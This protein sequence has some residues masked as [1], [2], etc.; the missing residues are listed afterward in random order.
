MIVRH[1]EHYSKIMRFAKN[2][3]AICILFGSNIFGSTIHINQNLFNISVDDIGND[4]TVMEYSFGEFK[5]TDVVI[6]GDI[7]SI[8]NVGKEVNIHDMGS[9]TL[10]KI[11]RSI[12]I[13]DDK[14]M[15]VNI[16][17]SEFIEYSFKIA[18]GKGVI[19]RPDTPSDIPFTFSDIYKQNEYYPGNLSELGDPYIL[20]DFRGQTVTVYPFQYNPVTHSL[21]VY[22]H[23]KIEIVPTEMSGNN[24]KNRTINGYNKNFESLYSSHFINY[25]PLLYDTIDERGRMIV[26]SYGDFMD[27]I[28]PFVDWKN[29]KG[30]QCDLYDVY[31]LGAN[32]TGIKN[33]IQSEYDSSDDLCFVQL[34]GDHAQVPSIIVSNAGGGAS[35]PSFSLLE[36]NDDYPEIF[37]GRFSASSIS[38][39]ETQVERSIHYERD[40]I[41]GSWLHKG[42]GIGSNQGPGDDGEMDNQ[43]LDVIRDKLL[44]YTYPEIGQI[45]DPSGNDQQGIDA[46]NSGRGIINY[47]GH[48]SVTSWGNGASLNINQ[49]NNLE[50][51]WQL[52]HVISVGCVNG[53]FENSTCFAEAWMRSTNNSSGAPTGAVA[54]YGSTVNQYWNQPMRAQDHAMDLLV[55][56]DYSTNQTISQKHTIGG[57]WYNGSCNMMDVYGSSGIDMFLTWIIF[58]D[59]SLVVR[60]NIPE[61]INVSHTGTLFIGTDTYSVTTGFS[62]ALVSLSNEGNLLASGYT[63]GTGSVT[64]EI[65]NPPSEPTDLTLT[66]TAYDRIANVQ[67]VTVIIPDGP[68]IIINDVVTSTTDDS[69]VE[70]GE[71]VSLSISIENLGVEPAEDITFNLSTNDSY[72][73]IVDETETLEFLDINQTIILEHGFSGDVS[74]NVPNDYDIDCLLEIFSNDNVW[75]ADISISAFAPV[76]SVNSISIENDDNGNGILDPGESADFDLSIENS[77]GTDLDD[78]I[79]NLDSA[80]PYIT[81]IS[82]T[83]NNNGIE[84][85]AVSSFNFTIHADGDTPLGYNAEFILVGSSEIGFN[86]NDSFV[87]NVGLVLEDFETGN[88]FLYHWEFLGDASWEIT[89]D[90]YEGSFSAKSGE[91]FDNQSS[92][93]SLTLNV[94]EEG[95]ISFY[96]QVSS[97]INNDYL[98]FEIDN[99]LMDQWSGNIEWASVAYPVSEGVHTFKWTYL[100]DGW[101]TQ[102]DDCSWI[103][104]I[105]FPTI[106]LPQLPEIYVNP[107]EMNT[108]ALPGEA[109]TEPLV[110]ENI[111]DE[112]LVYNIT[113]SASGARDDY[114][115]D[116]PDSPDQYD[117]DYDTHTDQGWI[118]YEVTEPNIAMNSWTILFN[119]ETDW[120]PTEGSFWVTSPNG[121]TAEIANGLE[122]G[123]HSISLDNFTGEFLPGIWTI[124]IED[125]YGDGGH[126]ATN[127]TMIVESAAPENNWLSVD[128]YSG[129]VTPSA[130]QNINVLCDATDLVEGDYHGEILIHSNDPFD[131]E[132]VVEIYFTVGNS[133]Y[134]I[135]INV[136]DNW[137]MVG[138]PVSLDD[139]QY[140]TIFPNAIENTLFSFGNNGYTSEAE[141][142][143]GSGYWL[144][145]DTPDPVTITGTPIQNLSISLMEGWNLISGISFPVMDENI[146]DPD[147]IIIIN[148]IYG[149]TET[150]YS[151]SSILNPGYGYWIR[152]NGVGEIQLSSSNRSNRTIPFENKLKYAHRIL[153]NGTPLFFGLSVSENEEL[154][155]SLP[156]KPPAGGYDARY[157]NNMLITNDNGTIEVSNNKSTLN[158]TFELNDNIENQSS[159]EIVN[160]ETGIKY[161][162][163]DH[164]TLN[165]MGSQ[166]QF[167]LRSISELPQEYSLSQNFPNPFNSETTIS[168]GLPVDT[169]LNI[170]IYNLLGQ[171]IS[172]LTSGHFNAGFHTLT[173][174]GISDKGKEVPAGVYL[175]TIETDS[176]RD[177]KK[178]ILMK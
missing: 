171:K 38:Q 153:I 166:F 58:G 87:L 149:F 135:S 107:Q 168:F 128:S 84:E 176:Y 100:K 48:G 106:T 93:L 119:W 26:I 20:R 72:L 160:V 52:P 114:E 90:S 130:T 30:I 157:T 88:F 154:Q 18:S 51:D 131:S 12:I 16:L 21:K 66:V 148:T 49:V 134:D 132:V 65:M 24:I 143:L 151:V 175:Y 36:G 81:I 133:E 155:Y 3:M 145:F 108:T 82:G 54:F 120:W 113:H 162:I 122:S 89:E 105:M 56:Y 124:W 129:T 62:D 29:Q 74:P 96:R 15:T 1:W 23:L 125:T 136:I 8:L 170:S 178:M 22:H 121:T 115:F 104:Y 161:D 118:E 172:L 19:V 159:W 139:T 102:G 13:P 7:Y 32:S 33:F 50:N 112:I 86:Y 9:P 34:V 165:F 39:L 79:L 123:A 68:Y 109:N 80:S 5:K 10:P 91:I 2:I 146:I 97:A 47:T 63:D 85:S 103:D 156:P 138:L 95:D 94:L 14:K 35:D 6:N 60:S 25:N 83:D 169:E 126:Q 76:L 31:D 77:G 71:T 11:T 59:A 55:G 43:H 27:V 61:P 37:V 46:I 69:I 73:T 150:G 142:E 99:S 137:N 17:E 163:F 92:V 164:T 158:I 173:W 41:E 127:I 67:S 98:K 111:G 177:M 152:S 144:R 147:N 116:I 174:K 40:I 70:Y 140:Q 75:S 53:A 45:Y 64:L 141:L 78:F 57:L 4:Q 42:I 167:L 117:W 101:D 44:D 110:I 28:Q